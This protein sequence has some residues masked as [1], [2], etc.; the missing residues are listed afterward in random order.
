VSTKLKAAEYVNRF[1]IPLV[2]VKGKDKG[3]I[4]RLLDGQKVGTLIYEESN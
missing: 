2:V 1:K 4:S 3:V